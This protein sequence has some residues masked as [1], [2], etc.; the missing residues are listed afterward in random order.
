M[1]HSASGS[2]GKR[3]IVALDY[4]APAQALAMADRLDRDLCRV[5]VGKELFTR[6]GPPLVCMGVPG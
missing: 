2:S 3:I 6:A 4:P 1:T 5:K